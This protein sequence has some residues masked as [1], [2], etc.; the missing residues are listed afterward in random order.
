MADTNARIVLTAEDKTAAAMASLRNGLS[1]V[2]DKAISL[3]GAFGAL[4][5][6]FSFAS[7]VAGV[8]SINDGV[9][10]LNDLKDAT[11][12]SIENISALEDVADRT[13]TAFDTVGTALIKFNQLL[14]EA[15]PGSDAEKSLAAI[16]LRAEEL[17]NIDPAEALRRYAVALGSFADDGNKARLVQEQL[18]KSLREVAPFLNDLKEQGSLVAKVTTE[19]AEAA[20]QFNKQLFVLEKNAKDAG[21]A[22]TSDLVSGI[23]LAAQAYR[24]SGLVAGIQTLFTGDD[25]YKNNKALVEN[26]EKLLSLESSLAN[27]KTQ[28]YLDGSRVVENIKAQIAQ[29]KQA[30]HTTM[31]YRKVL[32]ETNTAAGNSADKPPVGSLPNKAK[33]TGAEQI[34]EQRT[35][36][37]AYVKGLNEQLYTIDKI[38]ES[39]QALNFL[40]SQGTQGQVPHV[41]ELVLGL[42]ERVD[43]EKKIVEVL[44]QQTQLQ[45]EIDEAYR[46]RLQ[47]MLESGPAAKLEK[48]REDIQLLTAEFEEGRISEEQYLDAVTGR[49][50]LV[51]DGVKDA[52]DNAREFGFIFNSAFEDAIVNGKDL[53]E[54]VQ[55]LGQDIARMAIRKKV[56]EPLGKAVGD[57]FGSIDFGS[58]FSFDGGGST[59]SGSR[60]GGLDGKGGFLAMMHP[61]ETVIDHT[62]VGS[63]S[64]GQPI[65]QNF[66]F[67]GP[68]DRGM[69]VTAA[70]LGA[71]MARDQARD[72]RARGRA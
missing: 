25:Q 57:F 15:T 51:A 38:S 70:Q 2:E 30:I 54:V 22:L 7:M 1:G 4:V 33:K 59:G 12:A 28:G 6:A 65:V 68:A 39:Q 46:N 8:K 66:N 62:R 3:R 44:R 34:D 14:S 11:G 20:E 37:A 31:A 69:V 42:A 27:F 49:L 41:R 47:G 71:A 32:A 72:D 40:A 9:D 60:S 19:Q 64:G 26:T 16:G 17:R 21:R 50:N 53:S 58:L 5:P 35:S 18:G 45:K 48:T 13:G 67:N 36:L 63:A 55:A 61:Q 43:Q 52:T 24:E 23:N 10:A 56:T 29:T